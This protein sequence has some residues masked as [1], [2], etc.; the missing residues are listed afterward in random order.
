MKKIILIII[1][2]FTLTACS[3]YKEVNSLAIVNSIGIDYQDNN[4]IVTLEILNNNINNNSEN[5]F[6]YTVKGQDKDIANA[7]EK[8]A[9]NLSL[10]PYYPHIKLCLI[11]KSVAKNHLKEISDYFLRNNYFRE[12]FYFLITDKNSPNKILSHRTKINP[13]PGKAI[14]SL[15]NNNSYASNSGIKINFI[16]FI[17]NILKYGKDPCTSVIDIDNDNFIINGMA[18]FN[19]YKLVGILNNNYA[20]LYNLLQSKISK[21]L[22][23]ITINNKNFSVVVYNAKTNK[24]LS[25]KSIDISGVYNAK[26]VNNEPNYNIKD[27]KKLQF[28]NKELSLYINNLIKDFIIQNQK[29]N[30]DTL[31]LTSNYYIK[32][33]IKDNTLWKN[34]KINCHIKLKIN[35]KGL[36]FKKYD[37]K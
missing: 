19:E 36:I 17:K 34:N 10:R 2:I 13:I 32:E 23:T 3:D 11:S 6:S 33:K 4:Y 5:V 20:I 37:R 12:N 22:F 27:Y 14:I 21:P 9:N 29:L 30:S 8:A 35:K 18:L 25:K 28:L 16:M 1:F 15:I 26:I 7:I 24:N 31:G